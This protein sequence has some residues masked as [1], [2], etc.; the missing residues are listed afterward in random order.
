[1][2]N[3]AITDGELMV[4]RQPEAEDGDIVAAMIDGEA[5]VK[6]LRRSPD[7]VW[8]KAY[9]PAYTPIP[10]DDATIW[11]GSHGAAPLTHEL[12]PEGM[13]RHP[14]RSGCSPTE[15][16]P[17]SGGI[18]PGSRALAAQDQ[19]TSCGTGGPRGNPGQH[20]RRS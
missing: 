10:A 17:L 4:V 16:R 9:N 14:R 12:G 18:Q 20:T 6:T 2:I 7:Q 15:G 19:A 8:L 5:T 11:Q 13:P 1:M 3:A